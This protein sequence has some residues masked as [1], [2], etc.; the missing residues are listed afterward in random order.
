M[1]KQL[2]GRFDMICKLNLKIYMAFQACL[3]LALMCGCTHSAV[4][5]NSE[6]NRIQWS[7]FKKVNVSEPVE[8]RLK[9]TL[10]QVEKTKFNSASTTEVFENKSLTNTK[11]ESVDFMAKTEVTQISPSGDMTERLTTSQKDGVI[12][13]HDFA[14]PEVGEELMMTFNSQAKVLKAG[15]FSPNSLYFVPPISLP[16]DKVSVGDTWT[17]T[18][19][20]I[21][22]QGVPLSLKLLSILKGFVACG[23]K[24]I[25]ADIELSGEVTI[26]S[27][28][29][30]VSFESIWVGRIFFAMERGSILWSLVESH[31]AWDAEKV[32]REVRSCLESTLVE[33]TKYLVWPD[34]KHKCQVPKIPDLKN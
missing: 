24:D 16:A 21:T 4:K 18:S 9:A 10:G 31:E 11:E 17:M 14:M 1:K 6:V 34:E 3:A 30:G 5:A 32:H 23:E 19:H 20:W 27:N 33:P 12:D 13:L 28:I 29:G 8:L 7:E 26:D 15:N 25:C 2:S 22:E